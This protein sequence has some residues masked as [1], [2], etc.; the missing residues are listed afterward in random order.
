M[1]TCSSIIIVSA[2]G[3]AVASLDLPHQPQRWGG[4]RTFRYASLARQVQPAWH[5]A[6]KHARGSIGGQGYHAE[7]R[8]VPQQSR[9]QRRQVGQ[10]DSESS[11]THTMDLVAI[12]LQLVTADRHSL[13]LLLRSTST[14]DASIRQVNDPRSIKHSQRDASEALCRLYTRSSLG[15]PQQSTVHMTDCE[16]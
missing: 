7:E 10:G 13:P 4:N 11:T 6:W 15:E 8:Q 1:R 14:I 5:R 12:A 16:L 9:H 3:E 2:G